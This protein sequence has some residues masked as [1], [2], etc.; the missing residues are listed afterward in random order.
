MLLALAFHYNSEMFV[1]LTILN[2]E[3]LTRLDLY[4]QNVW[5]YDVYGKSKLTYK[6]ALV[7]STLHH[8]SCMLQWVRLFVTRALPNRCLC[9]M[10]C[11]TST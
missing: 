2:M 4:R 3:Y 11:S 10:A 7:I 8:T 6:E 5:T 1:S 9:S